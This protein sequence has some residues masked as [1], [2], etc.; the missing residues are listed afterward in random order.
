[1]ETSSL[2]INLEAAPP[3]DQL[4]QITGVTN[5]ETLSK[6]KFRLTFSPDINPT[7]YLLSAAVTKQWQLTQLTPEQHS[8]EDVFLKII[9]D[10]H[11]EAES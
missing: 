7:E 2:L 4:T 3:I 11:S 10:E 6:T 8:L 5:V 1:M 9:Q